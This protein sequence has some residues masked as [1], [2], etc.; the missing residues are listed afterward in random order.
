MH[1]ITLHTHFH[2]YTYYYFVKPWHISLMKSLYA[3]KCYT[4]CR[5]NRG[6]FYRLGLET[7]CSRALFRRNENYWIPL[8]WSVLDPRRGL[9]VPWHE[10]N[11]L[12]RS[13]RRA[14]TTVLL[15]RT[16]AGPRGMRRTVVKINCQRLSNTIIY[17]GI[18]MYCDINA[19]LYWWNIIII[20]STIIHLRRLSN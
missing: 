15:R 6:G 10:F 7:D 5:I 1:M 20:M 18:Y 19:L 11:G 16:A 14:S 9:T 4:Y 3:T 17:I 8:L 13:V 2:R 12:V